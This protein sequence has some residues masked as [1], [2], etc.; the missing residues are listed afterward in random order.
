MY[1]DDTA[2]GEVPGVPGARRPPRAPPF[3]VDASTPAIE[4]PIPFEELGDFTTVDRRTA[5]LAAWAVPIGAAGALVAVA[6]LGLIGLVTNLAYYGRLSLSFASPDGNGLGFLA[7]VVPVAGGV[8]VG[9]IARYG[10]ERVRGH[11][12]PEALE[13]ILVYRSRISPKVTVLKPI[14][15]AISIG[16]GGP[17]G[18]EGPIIMTGGSLGSVI[19]QTRSLSAAERKTLL[20]AGAG[21][22]MAA[23]FNTPIAAVLLAVEL[24]LFEWRPRSLIPV[25]VASVVATV[26]RWP[27]LGA[28]PIFPLSVAPALTGA[29]LAE[30]A[31][32]GLVVGAIA[33]VLTWAVYGFEDL[34]RR[35]PIHWMWWPAIGGGFIGI[36]GLLDPRVLGVG[37]GTIG[38]VL[39]GGLGATAV[40]VLLVTKAAVWTASLGSGTSGGVLAPL[41]MIGASAGFLGGGHLAGASPMAWAVIGLGAILA[42]TMRVPFTGLLFA[43]EL[44]DDWALLL[45]LFVASLAAFALTVFTMRRS[46]L[47]E[48]IARRRVHVAREY[49]VDPLEVTSVRN[50]MHGEVVP[51]PAAM[52]IGEVARLTSGGDGPFVGYPL[53]AEGGDLVGFVSRG[54]L[55]AYLTGGGDPGRPVVALSSGPLSSV[56]PDQP[57]RI[58]AAAMAEGDRPAVPVADADDPE[59]IVGM[60]AREDI[61]MARV[62]ALEDEQ[63]RDRIIRVSWPS[64]R[65]LELLIPPARGPGGRRGRR[66]HAGPSTV[67]PPSSAPGPGPGGGRPRTDPGKPRSGSAAPREVTV[68]RVSPVEWAEFRSL[69]LAALRTDP[70][71]FG[72]TFEA[73]SAYPDERWKA[74]CE[75]GA[76]SGREATFVATGPGGDWVGMLGIFFDRQEYHLWGMWVRPES[77]GGGVGAVLMQAVLGWLDRTVAAAPI[78]LDV[79]PVQASA[80]RLYQRFGFEFAGPER[81]LGHSAPAVR[82]RMRLVCPRVR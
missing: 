6:L 34:Y 10:S 79:N 41:L 39:A 47:T 54:Q 17:F 68:R 75:R 76:T 24:L 52:S 55:S 61:F 58:A 67:D 48:K 56:T 44:T 29:L 38:L 31:V 20:V 63:Q 3:P 26:V 1:S 46:I 80:V 77:R 19:G 40:A 11:G 33:T 57:L 7:V 69:R 81:P 14:S 62:L 73:E 50:V 72:S 35:L 53:V 71:A 82:R 37:Y 70:L 15:A 65:R 5:Y 32:L 21:A 66:R 13:S 49:A 45:P 16:T 25:G 9:L 74:W 42:G 28:G 60:V 4:R 2:D 64:Y 36:G 23:T 18:A 51:V 27:I 22:G 43:L 59:R 12:I 78:V 8:I 30:A